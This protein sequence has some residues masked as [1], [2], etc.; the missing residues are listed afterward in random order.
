VIHADLPSWTV[1]AGAA[2]AGIVL[3]VG[4]LVRGFSGYL[5][6]GRIRG[7]AP[8]RVSSIAV[9]E[10]L[11]TGAVE[12]AEVL[13]VSPLQSAECVYYRARISDASDGEGRDAF[14]EDR[15]VGFRV[16][17]ASGTVRVFP[18]GARF[19]VPE[20]YDETAA[21]SEGPLGLRPRVG[22]VYAPG[23]A[24]RE[25]RIAQLLT[26]RQP[27]GG[28]PSVLGG[29]GFGLSAGAG[30]RRYR[31][32]RIEPGDLVTVVGR[33]LP[34]SE[35]ADP[36]EANLV[37]GTGLAADDPEIAGDLAEARAAGLLETTAEAA[38]GNAAIPGFGIG[39]PV[40]PPE[41]DPEAD[42]LPLATAEAAARAE[43]TFEIAPEALILATTDDAP[44]AISLG[45]PVAA[46]A[47]AD[48]QFLTG[49]FGAVLAIGSAVGLA[50]LL[51]RPVA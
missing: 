32:A 21:G 44:L 26:V 23:P 2:A 40:R 1:A 39:R 47:R 29:S 19:D 38:W 11:V 10:V 17:D 36:A 5:S 8:S 18:R 4:L 37:E 46:A 12:P 51:N 25:A 9:G 13:L 45:A 16:R 20:R 24:D 22:S 14:R 34:F 35:L 30:R 50:L 3:G 48:W 49:L 6:A 27:A 15:A 28:D 7:T 31:E 33:A 42:P 43:A 41:L